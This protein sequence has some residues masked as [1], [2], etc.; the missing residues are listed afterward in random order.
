MA[1]TI[2]SARARRGT[3]PSRPSQSE[4]PAPP[5]P[6]RDLYAY[7]EP[8][9]PAAAASSTEPAPQ[10]TLEF[11]LFPH[12]DLPL[13]RQDS[14]NRPFV[15]AP[16]EKRISGPNGPVIQIGRKIDRAAKIGDQSNSTN[17]TASLVGPRGTTRED[18]ALH[19]VSTDPAHMSTGDKTAAASTTRAAPE[20]DGHILSV[21]NPL[22]A[23]VRVDGGGAESN[24]EQAPVPAPQAEQPAQPS[25]SSEPINAEPSASAEETIAP[26][27]ASA[28]AQP[29]TECIAFRSKVVSRHHAEIFV[30]E[31]GQV[32]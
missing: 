9:P 15:F 12:S 26:A 10:F 30:G 27:V 11:Q 28:P 3:Q 25:S 20:G 22:F 24:Q 1:R 6:E 19:N 31:D 17:G 5:P 16:V 29:P 23:P 14:H 18:R 13:H 32:G 2:Q 21:Y 8:P 7:A 4:A